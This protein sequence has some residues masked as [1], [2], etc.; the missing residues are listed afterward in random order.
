LLQKFQI[1]YGWK[2]VEIGNNFPY[3]NFSRLEI[4]F[5]IKISGIFY[6]LNFDRNSLKILRTSEFDEI[7]LASALLYLIARK[8]QFPSKEH[9]KVEFHSKREIQLISR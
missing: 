4:E 2:G 5:E 8:N 6:E 7:W 1:K 3:I 9:R